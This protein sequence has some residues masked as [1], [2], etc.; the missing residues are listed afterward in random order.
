M[1]LDQEDF[2]VL[3]P[4]FIADQEHLNAVDNLDI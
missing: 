4:H 1:G 3:R 2:D